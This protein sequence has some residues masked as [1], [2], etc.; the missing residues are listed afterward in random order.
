MRITAKGIYAIRAIFDLAHHSGGKPVSLSAISKRQHISLPFLAQIFH[1]LRKG[2][3]VRSIRGSK[4]GF[5]LT[6]S[7]DEICIGDVLRIIEAPISSFADAGLTAGV[8]GKRKAD[9]CISNLL[10]KR[11]GEQ[12]LHLLDSTSFAD[13]FREAECPELCSFIPSSASRKTAKK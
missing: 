2:G 3:I 11:L 9:E 13:L 7:C 5:V 1:L 6:R 10:W 8:K 12:I 4:G